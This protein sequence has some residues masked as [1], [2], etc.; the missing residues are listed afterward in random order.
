MFM[1][2][3]PAK[4]LIVADNIV[5]L[6]SNDPNQDTLM[7]ETNTVILSGTE[8]EAKWSRRI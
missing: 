8:P 5:Y 6:R 3:E 7:Q 2:M 1:R 4:S